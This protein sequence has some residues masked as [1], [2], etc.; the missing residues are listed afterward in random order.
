MKQRVVRERVIYRFETRAYAKD[1]EVVIIAGAA[2]YRGLSGRV[3]GSTGTLPT[4]VEVKLDDGRRIQV[5]PEHL[6]RG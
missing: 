3:K 1:E 2:Q 6:V 4:Q 5:S